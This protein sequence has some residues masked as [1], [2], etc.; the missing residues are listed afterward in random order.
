[1]IRRLT[2]QNFKSLYDL[3]SLS[4]SPI[5]LLA[6]S[7]N[8]GKT[9]ILQAMLLTAQSLMSPVSSRGVVLNGPLVRLGTFSDVVSDDSPADAAISIGF[10]IEPT[11]RGM[12][13]RT[14]YSVRHFRGRQ[15]TSVSFSFAFDQY[16]DLKT[17]VGEVRIVSCNF[18]AVPLPEA[19]S[20]AVD[21]RVRLRNRRQAAGLRRQFPEEARPP[22]NVPIYVVDALVP[23]DESPYVPATARGKVVGAILERFLPQ[24]L[25]IKVNSVETDA[26]RLV[27]RLASGNLD[28]AR[29]IVDQAI[30]SELTALVSDLYDRFAA[31]HKDPRGEGVARPAAGP[32]RTQWRR[33]VMTEGERLVKAA[34]A[35]RKAVY[36]LQFLP[37]AVLSEDAANATS[38]IRDLFVSRLKYLGPLRDEPKALY[39]YSDSFDARDIGLRGE[40]TASVFDLHKDVQVRY[41]P[42]SCFAHPEVS[43]V[44]TVGTLSEAVTDWST[45]L[46]IASR[47]S[48]TEHG[49]TG[50]D[51]RVTPVG[52][53]VQRDLTHVGVGVSQVL[54]ILVQALLADE[55]TTMI[56][57]QPELHLN[58]A[59]QTR[60]ADFFLSMVPL[61]KQCIVE[62]HSE[63]LVN[64]LRL[65]AAMSTE[66]LEDAVQI[67]FVEQSHGRTTCR[68]LHVDAFGRLDD[69]PTG[70]FDEAERV[71]SAIVRAS[72]SKKSGQRQSED[73]A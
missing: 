28:R 15:F 12:A 46:G 48:A 41:V 33:H 22:V 68:P 72:V 13:G 65:R 30:P 43:L 50:Y 10:Q 61:R 5:T 58:P 29:A 2:V 32:Q 1:M 7:N 60:L 47:I 18:E 49:N 14:S 55:G 59:L 20:E 6:G 26:R 53:H 71:S 21:M 64:G 8:S 39:P 57:E 66:A 56:F 17:D 73:K 67:Y 4:L 9:T 70:F 19:E 45:Y 36:S 38:E 44:D 63:H 51:L 27:E 52:S 3:T 40:R 37:L 16:V 31:T 11:G 24:A 34:I 62:T 54:P 35:S 23:L 25:A 69:W 42:S